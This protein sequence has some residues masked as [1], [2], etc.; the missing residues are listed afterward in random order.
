M[1]TFSRRIV[2][3][4]GARIVNNWIF[5]LVHLFFMHLIAVVFSSLDLISVV[6]HV[7]K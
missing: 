3:G 7:T 2:Q 5:V 6:M 4:L 1:I